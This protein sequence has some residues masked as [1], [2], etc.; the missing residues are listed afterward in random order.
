MKQYLIDEIRLQDLGKL[1]AYLDDTFGESGID[2]LYWLPLDEA[3][4]ND[5]QRDHEA[6]APFFMALELGEDRLSAELLVR[7][8]SRVRCDCMH[9]ADERQ[10]S[11]LVQ[12]VDAI[13]DNLEI[14]T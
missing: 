3:C 12:T 7:T 10:R 11:W 4:F 1:K 9:Y 2:G 13:F 5:V 6:C 8:R 14:I